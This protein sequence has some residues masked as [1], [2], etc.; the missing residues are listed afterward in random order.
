MTYCYRPIRFIGL[1]ALCL[2]LAPS[3]TVTGEWLASDGPMAAS[4]AIPDVAVSVGRDFADLCRNDPVRA[5]AASIGQYDREVEGYTCTFVKQERINGKLHDIETIACDFRQSPYSVLMRWT[6]GKGRADAMLYVAGDNDG[7]LLIV[8]SHDV[9]K[10]ALRVLGKHYAKRKLDSSDAREAARYPANQFGLRNAAERVYVAWKSAGDRGALRVEYQGVLDVP[11]LGGR[12]CHVLHRT[13]LAP[14]EDGLTEVTV[15]L[16]AETEFQ[17]GAV[18]RAGQ[19]PIATY[20][21]RDLRLN[22]RYPAGHFSA[23]GLR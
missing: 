15:F 23:A 9:A 18:L 4:E 3:R 13:C 5:L 6:G 11:E 16:D 7:D 21:F 8:P 14:E 22:P 20:Y 10:R 12:P 17:V 19:S 2:A 1:F